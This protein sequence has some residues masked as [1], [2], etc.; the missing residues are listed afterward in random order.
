MSVAPGTRKRVTEGLK[1]IQLTLPT[2]APLRS[3]IT[4]ARIRHIEHS[5]VDAPHCWAAALD[6]NPAVSTPQAGFQWRAICAT[7][8][9]TK[10]AIAVVLSPLDPCCTHGTYP[11]G[12]GHGR[13]ADIRTMAA[14]Q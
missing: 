5:F 2:S 6:E 3:S 8:S 9:V 4:T 10:S 1:S 12:S 13:G 7:I 11:G 14:A